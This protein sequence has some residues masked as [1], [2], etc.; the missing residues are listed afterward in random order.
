MA[1]TK[2]RIWVPPVNR[3][4][5]AATALRQ[6][7]PHQRIDRPFKM[8]KIV[9]KTIEREVTETECKQLL[10]HELGSPAASLCPR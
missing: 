3:F 1:I 4:T 7:G 2:C 9:S 5:G 6:C 8:E 10:D